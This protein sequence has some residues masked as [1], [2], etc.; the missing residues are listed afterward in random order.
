MQSSSSRSNGGMVVA[1][2]IVG[3]YLERDQ[4]IKQ[5]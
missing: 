4:Q 3:V 2:V 5:M 1:Q